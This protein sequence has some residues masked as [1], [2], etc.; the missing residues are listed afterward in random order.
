MIQPAKHRVGIHVMPVNERI[1]V[2]KIAAVAVV[3]EK[4]PRQGKIAEHIFIQILEIVLTLYNRI[5]NSGILQCEPGSH[6]GIHLEDLLKS[7]SAAGGAEL[8][9]ELQKALVR[10]R[11][12]QDLLVIPHRIGCVDNHHG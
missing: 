9:F 2:G 4:T 12:V 7:H 10:P 6:V 5:V 8:R 1:S 11:S 3:Q